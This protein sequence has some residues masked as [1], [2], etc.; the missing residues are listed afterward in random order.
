MALTML[1][2]AVFSPM[3]AASESTAMAAKTGCRL[4][5]RNA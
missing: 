3:P 1:N 5:P 4:K 2:T